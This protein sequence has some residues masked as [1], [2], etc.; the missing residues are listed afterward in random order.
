M[1]SGQKNMVINLNE[2][3]LSTDIN[4]LQA[5]IAQ[6]RN[7]IIRALVQR[8]YS[9]FEQ[10]GVSVVDSGSGAAP[11][12]ATVID[13]LDMVVDNPGSVLINPGVLVA[14]TGPPASADDS[15]F[16]VI[17]D[18]GI[19]STGQLVIAANGGGQPRCDVIECG[20][21]ST[22]L[23]G[24]V[25]RD[26]RNPST[27]I[28]VPTNVTKVTKYTLLYRVWQG[29]PGTGPGYRAGWLPL[30]I[31]VVQPGATTAQVD[32]YDVR[33]LYR[34]DGNSQSKLTTGGTHPIQPK[35]G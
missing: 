24:N 2:R 23:E 35:L 29:T 11:L 8:T 12:P 27:G 4:R 13:G 15:G 7:D 10:P 32:F 18:A 21:Q 16:V 26:I 19:Q 34:E 28:F 25:S 5:F 6:E 33:P 31:A 20:I 3:P 30:G 1:S 17:D 22:I 14:W 9:K